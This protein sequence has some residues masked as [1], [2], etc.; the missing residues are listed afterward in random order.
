[1]GNRPIV[2]RTGTWILAGVVAGA[3]AG[4]A[5]VRVISSG[6]ENWSAPASVE[7]PT[8]SGDWGNTRYSTLSAVSASTVSTL[9]GTW[10]KKFDDGG[11]GRATPVVKDGLMFVS[12][13]SWIYAF[14]AKTGEAVWRY[15]SGGSQPNGIGSV[16]S[17]KN[18]AAFPGREGVAVGEGLVFTGLAD[19]TV[20]ALREKT[21]EVAWTQYVGDHPPRKG[22]SANGAPIYANSMVFVG[23]AADF[24]FR[25]QVVALDAR[26]GHELWRWFAI[27]APGESGS[28]TWPRNNGAWQTGG[29]A[30]WLVGAADPSLG[31]VYFGTG[32]AVPQ[33]GGDNRAGDNLYTCSVVA[34]DMKTG[35]LRWHYQIIR[36]D[37]WEADIAISPVLY[38]VEIGGRPRKAV[39][40]MRADGYLFLLD[41]ET[42]K[43]LMPV[44]ER[45]VPQDA[46]GKTAA[47]QLFPVNA[48]RV[49]PDCDEWKKQPI[50]S[51]FVLGCFFA[52]ASLDVPNLLAPSWGMRTTPMAYSPKTGYLYAVGNASLAWFRRAEDPSFF[53]LGGNRVPGLPGGYSVLAALDT[54]T[55]TIAWKKEYRA[56][57]P[58]GALTT[59]GGLLFQM[60]S[61]GAF[62]ALDAKTGDVVWQFQ[63]GA[64]GGAAPASTYQ[65]DGEQY[66]ALATR[67]NLWA[68]KLG[69]TVPPDP[70]VRTAAAPVARELF[71][72]PIQDVSDIE[73]VSNV[74]DMGVT[75]SHYMTDEYAFS[76]YR[77]RVKVGT[78]VRWTNNGRLVHTITAEDGSWTTGPLNPIQ[79]GVVRFD[80]PGTYTYMCKDHPWAKAQLVVVP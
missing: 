6:S 8:V 71:T 12:A 55:N 67:R 56:G 14:S 80:K 2:A 51:G 37:I 42:G 9:G 7:W 44:E 49:L 47:T 22:Q 17:K 65:I 48:S 45:K 68:F 29:G 52:P 15:Q 79:V 72:G 41:R 63:T 53:G 66:I 75:G 64:A 50:P 61:D 40:T 18:G 3:I 54:R 23:T 35:K 21:G 70:A 11:S 76:V 5:R 1:M 4:S 43:P 24:G 60:M 59:A 32:N 77:A 19:G 39:A 30:L 69:G 62:T 13:G 31:L 10:M 74:R 38:E 46:R 25:G 73:V 78:S 26:T 16:D 28:E 58:S 20:I 57:R 27:P 36:H 33:Y 34:L